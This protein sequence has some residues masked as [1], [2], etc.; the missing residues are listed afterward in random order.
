MKD[1]FLLTCALILAS[2]VFIYAQEEYSSCDGER[3]RV[4][5]FDAVDETTAIQFGSNTT[6]GGNT[7]DLFMD[8]YEPA[9]DT[10]QVRP[11]IVL[12]FGGAFVAGQREDLE[13]LCRTL[14]R[15]GY[16]A[17]TIDYRLFD[18]VLPLDS[19][20]MHDVVV[21]AIGDMKA[22]IRYLRQDAATSN[23]FRVDTN[24]IFAGGIS[25]GAITAAHVAHLDASDET[26]NYLQNIIANNGGLEGN[27]SDNYQYSSA[28]A[29]L[30]N[31]SGALKD[32]SFIDE[33]D[34]PQFSVHDEG[35][36]I[37]VY[38]NGLVFAGPIVLVY[39]EGS[40]SMDQ[41]A[42]AVGVESRLITYPGSGHVSYFTNNANQYQPEVETRTTTFLADQ[43]CG[44]IS[45]TVA[46]ES[47]PSVRV[48]PNPL[49]QGQP[50]QLML[51]GFEGPVQLKVHTITG[52]PIA[53]QVI[54]GSGN[55]SFP[56]PALPPG[57]Y[58]LELR[59]T[60]NQAPP[61]LRKVVIH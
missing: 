21:K 11:A 1:K 4:D 58:V 19:N 15:K 18:L 52:A 17:A 31:Y 57:I 3:Y 50:V 55:F 54:G 37:V 40:F 28:V 20:Q 33:N 2:M 49:P 7:Q 30:V 26:P 10:A 22:A 53:Q 13:D 25:A 46:F 27:S 41:Q 32:A 16:V 5:V 48:F 9:G 12:A 34:P 60:G 8:V 59:A 39:L 24:L 38:G 51:S 56:L 29:G 47:A 14:A 6:I 43:I 35:D 61:V 44:E 45:N 36:G 23:Q 42:Q